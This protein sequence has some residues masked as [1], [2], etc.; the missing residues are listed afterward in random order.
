MFEY[1]TTGK[2]ERYVTDCATHKTK[3]MKN[4]I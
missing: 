4:E 3:T 1:K 2:I